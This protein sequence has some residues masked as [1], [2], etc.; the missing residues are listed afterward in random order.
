MTWRSTAAA[1][2]A[3]GGSSAASAAAAAA[4]PP[5]LT[6][7]EAPPLF[8]AAE[9]GPHP[10]SPGNLYIYI[11][12][13]CPYAERA[14]LALLEKRVPFQLVHIDLSAKP[15]WFRRINPAGLVPAVQDAAGAVHTESADIVHWVDGA[16]EG[17]RLTPEDAGLRAEME[18]LVRG[19]CS[20]AVSAGLDLCAGQCCCCTHLHAPT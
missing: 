3:A 8:T 15:S 6:A 11:H 2:A 10:P 12:T 14:W 7:A 5:L 4:A 13:L 19:P 20:G 17:P 1:T 18:A 16:F 9:A